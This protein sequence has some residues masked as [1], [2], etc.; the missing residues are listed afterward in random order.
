MYWEIK[1]DSFE[2]WLKI[3]DPNWITSIQNVDISDR[4]DIWILIIALGD[5][6][7]DKNRF[8]TQV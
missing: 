2:M 1:N 3:R 8:D 7:G 4:F 5:N 6:S